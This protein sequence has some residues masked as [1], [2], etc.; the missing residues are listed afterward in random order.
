MKK[1]RV[2]FE[3]VPLTDEIEVIIRASENDEQAAALAERIS[4][5]PPDELTGTDSNGNICVIN[6]DDII[7]VAMFGKKA[8]IITEEDRYT[9]R[10]PLQSIENK[11][12]RGRFV[13]ISRYEIINLDKVKKYDFTLS[14]TL[15]LELAGGM[16]TW[17]SRRSIPTIKKKLTEG[18]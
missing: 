18:K 7:S 9:L 16:E 5:K 15:R 14:G 8:H 11:L 2:V 3:K 1:I 13:R 17:A 6:I 12:E 10:S 4:Q